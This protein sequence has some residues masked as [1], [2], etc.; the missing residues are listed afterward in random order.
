M[1]HHTHDPKHLYPPCFF[2]SCSPLV[3]PLVHAERLPPEPDDLF[4]FR[5]SF[6][7]I[8]AVSRHGANP[9]HCP[10][11]TLPPLPQSVTESPLVYSARLK[12][13][14]R[15]SSA[16]NF[17]FLTHSFPRLLS[18]S[19]SRIRFLNYRLVRICFAPEK[20]SVL[21]RGKVRQGRTGGEATVWLRVF[22]GRLWRSTLA[23]R[24]EPRPPRLLA[25][26]IHAGP[27]A[28]TAIRRCAH[29]RAH[30]SLLGSSVSLVH[31]LATGSRSESSTNRLPAGPSRTS[32]SQRRRAPPA[33]KSAFLF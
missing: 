27:A 13:S 6:S 9:R 21:D 3:F 28:K 24:G 14:S 4:T 26:S 18:L 10:S 8:P 25:P 1:V 30:V 20:W 7:T 31:P 29:T 23:R 16:R 17:I 5:I 11:R 33:T 32:R 2:S 19:L 22:E 12:H 15:S